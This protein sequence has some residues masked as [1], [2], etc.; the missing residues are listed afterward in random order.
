MMSLAQMS[1]LNAAGPQAAHIEWVWWVMLWVTGIVYA[2]VMAFFFV[3][4]FRRTGGNEVHP[5]G[6]RTRT[7][8]VIGAT[9]VS[10]LILLG[11]L[12][13]SVLAGRATAQLKAGN[14]LK[15]NLTGKQWWW[16]VEYE[17]PVWSR[18][19][20]TA[21]EI[22][23]PVGKPLML[24]L[25][26][27]DVIH[28]F[29]IPS[30]HGKRDLIPGE[31]NTITV[32]ADKPGVYRGQCA[33]FCGL[34]HAHMALF[35]VAEPQD[36]FDRWYANQVAPAAEPQTPEQREGQQVF[37]QSSCVMCHQ[38]R[39]TQAAARFGPDLTHLKSRGQ[40]AAGTLPNTR[41]SLGG[42]IS[43]PH[44]VKPGVKMPANTLSPEQLSALL[45]Y[46]ESLR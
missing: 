30:L 45:G 1:A 8:W 3:A 17:D 36:A 16:Q 28:S 43:S 11:L 24:T 23:V 42:W 32:R 21:N 44:D 20:Q 19:F 6:E 2:A 7:I 37:L 35:V 10:A 18:R 13:V 25:T 31:V 4:I 15:I 14:G 29:W 12:V 41:G 38:V 22:H 33:E 39:G 34:Q 40:I 46:L 27:S 5:V 26:S 9:A